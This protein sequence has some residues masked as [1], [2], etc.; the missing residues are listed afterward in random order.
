[1]TQERN[2]WDVTPL[3]SVLL[4]SRVCVCVRARVQGNK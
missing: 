1:M 3:L 2:A 4:S